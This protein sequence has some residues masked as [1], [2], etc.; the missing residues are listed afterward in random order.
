MFNGVG[1]GEVA[2]L[3]VIGLFVFGP[4]RLPKAARD[5]GRMLRQLR[6][7]A[8]GMRNDLRSELGP[9]FDDL[10]IRDL[11][12]KTFVRKHLFD[13]EPLPPYLTKRTSLDALLLAEDTATPSLTKS[14]SLGRAPSLP[15]ASVTPAPPVPAVP[16][17]AASQPPV[18][19]DAGG[20]VGAQPAVVS[21][22]LSKAA[23]AKGT[24]AKATAPRGV[25]THQV[26]AGATPPP[27]P[28]IP[29][30]S[31]AT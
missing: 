14:P 1:W 20:A 21:P 29:F 18:G 15:A 24:G 28:S 7:T 26:S 19:A 8:T 23:G 25:P 27:A 5:A 9:E 22:L 31:D 17:A 6:Q 10:D 4:D 13:D 12:P 11:H 2:V 30:D 3:L 16:P